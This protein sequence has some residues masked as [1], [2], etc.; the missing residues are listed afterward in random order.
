MGRLSILLLL[1]GVAACASTPAPP[2][3][4]HPEFAELRPA[5]VAIV[6]HAPE[7]LA[8]DLARAARGE[9]LTRN[10]SPLAPGARLDPDTGTLRIRVSGEA[11]T[12]SAEAIL[13]AAG[14]VEL[15]RRR[16]TGN[17]E[18]PPALVRLLLSKLPP[19]T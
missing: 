16:L 4:I 1:L 7:A 5:M 17:S 3:R 18:A 19:K 11:S 13:T 6:V 10:Y 9:L 15:Y 14:G 8:K 12:R 2:A